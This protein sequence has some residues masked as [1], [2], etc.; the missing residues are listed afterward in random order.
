MAA[1]LHI[2]PDSTNKTGITLQWACR[3]CGADTCIESRQV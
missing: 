1:G 3:G 2:K